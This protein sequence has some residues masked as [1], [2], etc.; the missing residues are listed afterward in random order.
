MSIYNTQIFIIILMQKVCWNGDKYD[1]E[2]WVDIK[3][4]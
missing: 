1:T 4:G 3:D 2:I